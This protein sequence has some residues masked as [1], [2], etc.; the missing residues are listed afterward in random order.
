MEQII[1]VTLQI[2]TDAAKETIGSVV[3]TRKLLEK[4]RRSTIQQKNGGRFA[5]RPDFQTPYAFAEANFECI[6]PDMCVL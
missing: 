1:P 3:P 6:G 4:Q 5:G 2:M